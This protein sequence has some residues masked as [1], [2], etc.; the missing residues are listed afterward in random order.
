MKDK[1]QKYDNKA[2][3]THEEIMRMLD[4]FQHLIATFGQIKI[5]I[6]ANELA[7]RISELVRWLF[8]ELSKGGQSK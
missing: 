3:Y 7:N 8:L 6:P 2:P 4:D 1:E 5:P